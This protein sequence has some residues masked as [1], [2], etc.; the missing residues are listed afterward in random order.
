M[1][2]IAVIDSSCLI[3]LV[4]LDLASK[5]ALFFDR[6]YIPRSVQIEFNRKHRSRYRLNKLLRSSAFEK[7]ICKDETN[8]RILS[9]E[10]GAGEAEGLVQAQ[11]RGAD[12]FLVDER[13]ARIIGQRQG[14]VAYG[15]VRLLARFCLDGYAA[16]PWILVRRLRRD[17]KFRIGDDVVEQAIASAETPIGRLSATEDAQ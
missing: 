9:A 17:L 15:T 11:E 6:I 16:D 5:L 4:H 14:L 13:K 12:W 2:R 7:C 3:N 8:F 10:L 1:M